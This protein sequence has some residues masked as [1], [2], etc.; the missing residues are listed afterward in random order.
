MPGRWPD[1]VNGELEQDA[2]IDELRKRFRQLGW[3]MGE[4]EV[5]TADGSA[6]W[7]VFGKRNKQLFSAQGS[8]RTLAW[9]SAWRNAEE[10]HHLAGSPER[11]TQRQVIVRFPTSDRK[12]VA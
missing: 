1:T 7:L 12:S 3:T 4:R 9:Q 2:M 11:D 5:S 10:L 6:L 8:T